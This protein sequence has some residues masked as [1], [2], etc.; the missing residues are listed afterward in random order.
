MKALET[1]TETRSLRSRRSSSGWNE[2]RPDFIQPDGTT[3]DSQITATATAVPNNTLRFSESAGRPKRS[4]RDEEGMQLS[5][6][7]GKT[8]E[9]T[10][11]S[12][13]ASKDRDV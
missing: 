6:L 10:A 7:S 2:E 11:S 13:N 8:G 5:D 3:P 4:G 12:S 1:R 9:D